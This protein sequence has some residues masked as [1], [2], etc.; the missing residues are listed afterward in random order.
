[1]DGSK[2]KRRRTNSGS[3]SVSGDDVT[4]AEVE[5][6]YAILRRIFLANNSESKSKSLSLRPVQSP[7]ATW[8]PSFAPEDFKLQVQVRK[9]KDERQ[10]PVPVAV[11]VRR[12]LD[13]N[14]DPEPDDSEVS[15]PT[16]G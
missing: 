15:A 7:P 5:E 2:S 12:L 9:D 3:G 14:A 13:L 11:A 10:R 16:S 6:F 1:M 8:S 4:D